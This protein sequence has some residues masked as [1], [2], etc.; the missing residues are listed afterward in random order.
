MAAQEFLATQGLY[1]RRSDGRVVRPDGRWADGTRE[2]IN[3]YRQRTEAQ[4]R[5][6]AGQMAALDTRLDTARTALG[7]A[8]HRERQAA[9]GQQLADIEAN[10]PWYQRTARTFGPW[11]GMV[12]GGLFGYGS[13]TGVGA[14][15]GQ[16]AQRGT[17]RA[18]ALLQGA[19]G[20][21]PQRVSRV[22]Q[23]WSEGGGRGRP[24]FIDE[25]TR[26]PYP[27]RTNPAG[28][29]AED[30]YLPGAMRRFGP[31]AALGG[32]AGGEWY[33]VETRILEPARR[34]AEAAR[35]A[36]NAD[37]NP[38]N[39]ARYQKALDDLAMAQS[40]DFFARGQGLGVGAGALKGQLKYSPPR[41]DVNRADAERAGLTTIIN[42]QNAPQQP[43]PPPPPP[44]PRPAA[45]GGRPA[46][47]RDGGPLET[48]RLPDG[49]T[50]WRVH[51]EAPW[52][53]DG[54][55]IPAG[56][57]R[58][59]P[60]GSWRISRADDDGLTPMNALMG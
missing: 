9:G 18:N 58:T 7:E 54:G 33:Y 1:G 21:V 28:T 10:T 8:Q 24:P 46:T 34:E 37:A 56:V 17:D 14:A 4:A 36:V 43:P 41:P 57:G 29:P 5:E 25:V 19:A 20:T 22:Q 35:A 53:S 45:G 27:Y 31:D 44:P 11:A 51:P 2:A 13:R 59:P 42:R 3:A 55:R 52:Q 40:L 23:F 39:V 50:I 38:V 6:V 49:R 12:A 16:V 48:Y 15:M 32:L 60:T 30:L 26:Q 47:G